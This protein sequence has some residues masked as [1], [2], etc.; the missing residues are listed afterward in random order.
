MTIG[1]SSMSGPSKVGKIAVRV[2]FYCVLFF[3]AF[4]A[5]RFLIPAVLSA[6]PKPVRDTPQWT[7]SM[8]N[9]HQIGIAM[10]DYVDKHRVFPPAVVYDKKGQPLYSWRVLLL[11][12]LEEQALY[13]QFKLDEPWDS[14]NNQ[15]LLARM[16]H[17]YLSPPQ[18]EPKEP[19]A[20]H[21]QVFTGGGAIFE[22]SPKAR[23]LSLKDISAADGTSKTLLVVEA[24]EPVPW[25]KPEDLPYSP[26]QPLP[27]LGGVSWRGFCALF[28]D[29]SGRVLPEDL[30][31]KTLRA[32]ITWNGGEKIDPPKLIGH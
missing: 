3:A 24:A 27:K 15:P 25:T 5:V 1:N 9:L 16:P 22:A 20:T 29:G 14:P 21:Y 23:L 8:Y 28:A 31:E 32:T 18:Y 30:D 19:Y 13:S 2:V 12:Y 7:Q 10:H 11:P 6:L 17:V 4:V 26:D